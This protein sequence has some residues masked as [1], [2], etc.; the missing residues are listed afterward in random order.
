MP[1]TMVVRMEVIAMIKK[2]YIVF[3]TTI[4]GKECG[5]GDEGEEEGREENK[6]EA[7]VEGVDGKKR[8][9]NR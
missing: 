6:I 5:V 7:E 9:S 1:I 8:P 3:T 4:T 2:N